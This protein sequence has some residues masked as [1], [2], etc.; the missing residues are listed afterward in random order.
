MDSK[1]QDE[2]AMWHINSSLCGPHSLHAPLSLQF[3]LV[4]I[5]LSPLLNIYVILMFKHHSLSPLFKIPK[6]PPQPRKLVIFLLGKYLTLNI[7]LRN[8]NEYGECD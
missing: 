8:S 2:D 3:S 4:F 1:L 7:N 6:L 5:Y